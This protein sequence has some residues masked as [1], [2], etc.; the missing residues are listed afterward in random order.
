MSITGLLA[1]GNGEPCPL[2][3][4]EGVK[5]PVINGEEVDILKHMIFEHKEAL[6]KKLFG[7]I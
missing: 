6:D 2:C 7:E 1:I 4:K 3:V 5:D